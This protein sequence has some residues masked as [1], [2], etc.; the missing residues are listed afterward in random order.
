MCSSLPWL[1]PRHQCMPQHSYQTMA[2]SNQVLQRNGKKIMLWQARFMLAAVWF[3]WFTPVGFCSESIAKF[4]ASFW[5][6]YHKIGVDT[7]IFHRKIRDHPA[8][9]GFPVLRAT[10]GTWWWR[11]CGDDR[12][13]CG[14]NLD[15]VF[16]LG[17][18]LGI[19]QMD[20]WRFYMVLPSSTLWIAFILFLFSRI[21][22]DRRTTIY[23][24]CSC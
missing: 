5:Q 12:R 18:G 14:M 24:C 20:C 7:S 9:F 8:L 17:G 23:R 21:R 4:P 19:K 22:D 6:V 1:N 11:R 2:D 13:S 15:A 16:F 10:S 3:L